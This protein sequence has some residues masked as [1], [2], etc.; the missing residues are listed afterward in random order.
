MT[1]R[2]KKIV[3]NK[4]DDPALVVEKVI[5]S[6]ADEI[7]LSIPR[8]SKLGE[9]LANFNLLKR[10][11][12]LLKKNL[13]IESTD[14]KV[15]ELAGLA[16][17]EAVNPFFL[18]SKRISDIVPGQEVKPRKRKGGA[19]PPAAEAES[20]EN[21]EGR[22]V[23]VIS[24]SPKTDLKLKLPA[25]SLKRMTLVLVFAAAAIAI[26]FTL[27]KVLPRAKIVIA[28]QKVNW[29]YDNSVIVDKTVSKVDGAAMQLPGQLFTQT[30]NLQLTFPASGKRNVERKASG[31]ITVYNAY[32]S[33]PQPLVAT[34]RFVTPDGKIFRLVSAITVPGAKIVEGKIVPSTIEASVAAD[35]AGEE[36]NIGPVSHFTIPGFKGTPK[37]EAF[38]GESKE[39]MAGGF[40]GEVAYPTDGDLSKA[41]EELRKKLEDS[42]VATLLTQIP[43]E[44]KVLPGAKQINFSQP[45]ISENVGSGGNFGI[46]GE[47]TASLIAFRETD[48]LE[49]L[50]IRLRGES[51][52]D[53]EL[54]SF[55][56][57]Y[58]EPRLDMA[59]GRM[60]FPVKFSA[61][62]A[63]KIDVAD[64]KAKVL[65][66]TESDLKALIFSVPGLE[67]AR[68]SLWPFW[69]KKVPGNPKRVEIIVE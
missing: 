38:Y 53:F 55:E 20:E 2:I 6:E 65:N 27:I 33:E 47:A 23:A 16:K 21:R 18:K 25:P 14:D 56:L 15:I 62:A 52:N 45:Q 19:E 54:K 29:N 67:S 9:S 11:A 10:E 61:V 37:F 39:P 68:I 51:G 41:K 60:S 63:R 26:L 5:D 12:G 22:H 40:I 31:K 8:F 1:K 7:V 36:Y 3:V 13:I 35:K 69:V 49:A 57:G 50:K 64:L 30:R 4:S 48:L 59:R 58:G 43:Q 24:E 17:L 44:F 66:K 28:S 46:F 34:T 42:L 32:S